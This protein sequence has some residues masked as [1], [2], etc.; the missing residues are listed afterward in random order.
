MEGIPRTRASP[1][2]VF[3]HWV[4]SEPWSKLG[5][6]LGTGVQE[7]AVMSLCS[8]QLEHG[9]GGSKE[10]KSNCTLV[11][12]CADCANTGHSGSQGKVPQMKA[13]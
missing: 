8:R 11:N 7:W 4:L 13:T 9:R 2:F 1:G 10:E 3:V 6:I 12:T 5:L